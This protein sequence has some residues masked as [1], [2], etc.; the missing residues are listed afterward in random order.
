MSEMRPHDEPE[1]AEASTFMLKLF[2]RN[3]RL[4]IG[5]ENAD[6]RAQE[7]REEERRKIDRLYLDVQ[8]GGD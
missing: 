3:E 4:R 8:G 2:D 7:L 6:R 5:W 1:T